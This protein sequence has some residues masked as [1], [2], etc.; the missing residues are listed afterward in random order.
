MKR[1]VALLAVESRA[2][3]RALYRVV[4]RTGNREN[5]G[6]LIVAASTA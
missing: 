6:R 1:E 5:P 3:G 4:S 2:V